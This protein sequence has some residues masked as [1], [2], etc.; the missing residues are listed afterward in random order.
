[1]SSRPLDILQWVLGHWRHDRPAALVIVTD[2]TGGTLRQK[3]AMMGVTHD[4]SVGYI[5]AGC[6]DADIIAQARAAL[7]QGK[8]ARIHYGDG[9]PFR[10]IALPCGGKIIVDIFPSPDIDR[11]QPLAG[12]LI[13]R[14]P[15]T[16]SLDREAIAF[17]PH[18][19]LRLIGRGAPFI[20]L[21][22]AA[23]SG[24][25]IIAQSPDIE[26]NRPGM[27][28]RF[29]H[30]TDPEA[31]PEMADDPWT[32]VV[33]LFHDHDWE[34]AILHQALHGPAFYVGAMGSQRT[35]TLRQ[36]ELTERGVS[37][38]QLGRLHAPIGLLPAMRDADWLAVSVLAEIIQSAQ[39][40]GRI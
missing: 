11:F 22:N 17:K 4:S 32:A 8:P 6:V 40:Q 26:L 5:S 35:Q 36:A 12:A 27:F 25:E 19:R 2:I 21:A 7:M 38:E 33:C 30:L 14:R 9:S 23:Q 13:A 39:K 15:Y 37:S 20:S 34:T 3:G 16:L 18:L 1:M 29:D 24:F 28:S 10:D 31:P